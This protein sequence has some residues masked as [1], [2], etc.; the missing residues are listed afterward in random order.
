MAP[1]PDPA[2]QRGWLPLP[3]TVQSAI[4]HKAP[5]R[6]NVPGQMAANATGKKT[7]DEKAEEDDGAGTQ[8]GNRFTRLHSECQAAPRTRT[9]SHGERTLPSRTTTPVAVAVYTARPSQ[10]CSGRVTG[11]KNRADHNEAL[12]G[13]RRGPHS[14]VTDVEASAANFALSSI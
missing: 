5:D 4:R 13:G 8:H 10:S 6:A 14:Q 2:Y 9:L 3:T 1:E 12:G 11:L 7:E